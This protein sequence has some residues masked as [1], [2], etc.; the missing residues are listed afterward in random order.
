MIR[1]GD[2]YRIKMDNN[3][4]ITPK[5]NDKYR[6][7]YIIIIGSDKNTIYGAVVTN[8]KDHH[9]VPIEFQ[10]PI[11][12]QGYNCYVNCYKLYELTSKRLASD[13]YQGNILNTNDYELIVETVKTSRLISKN[14]LRKFGLIE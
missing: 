4:G 6:Y 12:L 13:C 8:T 1:L 10:Y 2:I 7:K 5:E 11:S 3:D 14:K 9:L